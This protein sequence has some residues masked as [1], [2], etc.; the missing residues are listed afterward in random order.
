[1]RMTTTYTSLAISKRMS[2]IYMRGW[3]ARR[4]R[5]T[6]TSL[7]INKCMTTTYMRGRLTGRMRDRL[8]LTMT[9][10]MTP[11]VL[12]TKKKPIQKI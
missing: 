8:T 4:M 10:T 12:S 9:K 1:M 3:L 6:Y 5:A 11:L 7:G 2:T